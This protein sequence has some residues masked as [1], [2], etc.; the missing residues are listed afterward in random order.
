MDET[1][2]PIQQTST[3]I[4]WH[5]QWFQVR[6]DGVKLPDGTDGIYNVLEMRDSVFIV[7]VLTDGR[8][9]LIRN[10]RY[11]L[12][13]WVWELPAGGIEAGQTPEEAA[14]DEL[15]QEVGGVA[16]NMRFLLKANTMNGIGNHHANFYLA[17]NVEL[18]QPEHEQ[19]EF[20]HVHPMLANE[21]YTIAIN[22]QMNDAISITALLLARQHIEG[23]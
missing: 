6:E 16:E 1:Q 12:G 2:H 3:K 13:E 17:T 21:A 4:A 9:V 23:A 10:Y 5:S 14:R 19:M 11:T 22:G 15:L 18:Q 20:I 7:P 8:I